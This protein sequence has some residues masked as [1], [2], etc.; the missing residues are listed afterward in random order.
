MDICPMDR[1][2]LFPGL[3]LFGVFYNSILLKAVCF[4][5]SFLLTAVN[6][7]VQ[8]VK[9][10]SGQKRG[11]V[12]PKSQVIINNNN[13]SHIVARFVSPTTN[14]E[15]VIAARRSNSS[16]KRLIIINYF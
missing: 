16:C 4:Y 6:E 3:E 5:L 13:M 2:K 7:L 9:E 1:E 14:K 12:T 11:K 15:E 8:K 10:R